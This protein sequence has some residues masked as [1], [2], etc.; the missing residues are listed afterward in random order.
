[1]NFQVFVESENIINEHIFFLGV[2]NKIS[3]AELSKICFFIEYIKLHAILCIHLEPL[4]YFLNNLI[5][6]Y[7]IKTIQLNLMKKFQY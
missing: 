6:K 5:I 1:M 7:L 4:W 2:R 3:I